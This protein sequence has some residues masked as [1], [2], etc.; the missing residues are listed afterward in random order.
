MNFNHLMNKKRIRLLCKGT[1]NE[2]YWVPVGD[3][4]VMVG[5]NIHLQ[6]LCKRCDL[7]EDVFLSASEFN[8]QK[9]IIEKEIEIV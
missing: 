9:K 3:P 6:M 8:T 4:T 7:R 1:N 5:D 2:C